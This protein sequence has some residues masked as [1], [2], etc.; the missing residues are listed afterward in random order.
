MA[1]L[2]IITL[3]KSVTFA[4]CDIAIEMLQEEPSSQITNRKNSSKSRK[5]SVKGSR[6]KS[7]KG[8]KQGKADLRRFSDSCNEA[9]EITVSQDGIINRFKM[10]KRPE[11]FSR[12][13]GSAKDNLFLPREEENDSS[14]NPTSE[15]NLF[16]SGEEENGSSINL[17][18]KPNGQIFGS[19]TNVNDDTVMH[20]RVDVNGTNV[21]EITPSSEFRPEADAVFEVEP[22]V[23]PSDEPSVLPSDEP[24]VLQTSRS[25]PPQSNSGER[26][27]FDRVAKPSVTR[28]VNT[29]VTID[30]LVLWTKD[31][32]CENARVG[33][34][35]TRST[36]TKGVMDDL[37][38]AAISETNVAYEKSGVELQ[39]RLVHSELVDHINEP[40]NNAFGATLTAIRNDSIVAERR[41]TYGA[42]VVALLIHDNQYCGMGKQS[43]IFVILTCC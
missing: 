30:V 5:K 20:I 35:C 7:A 18:R 32:E 14:I 25:A 1:A 21:V 22:S 37:I 10:D 33:S 12:H 27:L 38:E 15:Q 9:T 41:A 39:L 29:F 40:V 11:A 42:D 13:S 3:N 4:Q 26:L 34:G 36:Y 17:L 8:R 19:M 23:L 31:A 24:S 2:G 43:N 28:R 16:L 6:K